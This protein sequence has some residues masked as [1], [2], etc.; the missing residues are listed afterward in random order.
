MYFDIQINKCNESEVIRLLNQSA[1]E[2]YNSRFEYKDIMYDILLKSSILSGITDIERVIRGTFDCDIFLKNAEYNTLYEMFPNACKMFNVNGDSDIINLGR[3]LE[4]FRNINAH[5]FLSRSDLE[6]FKF[7]YSFL[8]NEQVFNNQIKYYDNEITV[9]GILYILLNFLREESISNLCKKDFIFGLISN[10]VYS[11][12]NGEKFVKEI[13][14]VNLEVSIRKL[15]GSNI[16]NS[17]MGR[18]IDKANINGNDFEIRIGAT[19]YPTFIVNGK[20]EGNTITIKGGSLSKLFYQEDYRVIIEDEKDFMEISNQLPPFVFIDYLH[21]KHIE[22]FTSKEAQLIKKDFWMISKLNKP[23]FYVDKNLQVLLLPSTVSDFRIVSSVFTD[24]LQKILLSLESFIYKTRKIDRNNEFSSL[25]IA[26]QCINTPNDIIKETKYVRNFVAH[27]YILNEHIIY[28]N[29]TRVYSIK[30]VI[31]SLVKLC[32]FL[33]GQYSDI[34]FNFI[35]YIK[36]Y[37]TDI[38]IST[39]YKK[40]IIFSRE[41]M[42]TYPQFDK[43]ELAIKNGFVDNS[44]FDICDFNYFIIPE[45]RYN[46]I[47]KVVVPELGGNL[48]INNTDI[49]HELLKDFCIKIRSKISEIKESGF[50]S[51][52]RLN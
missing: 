13:S 21:E 9:A 36:N 38:L 32:E 24:S 42:K 47:I 52:Y 23:K 51:E 44:I 4:A 40:A 20:M 6:F 45:Y 30:Y 3:F 22:N 14:S 27:G 35:K 2:F 46:K 39:K 37:L 41:L 5:A 18:Y 49:D 43:K 1:K 17:I 7:D 48:Y 16:L 26:L 19:N 28:K 34:F 11:Y 50:L 15:Y 10:G 33:K 31:K 29:E 25:G 8:Q 12:D